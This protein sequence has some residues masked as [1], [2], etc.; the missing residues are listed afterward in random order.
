MRVLVVL[1]DPIIVDAVRER[2]GQAM[3]EGHSV[4]VC[5]V[6]TD[7]LGLQ[8]VLDA[9]RRVTQALRHALDKRAEGV[10]VFVASERDGDRIEDCARA[11]GATEVRP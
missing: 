8:A 1:R 6:P 10:P 9:Q 11:W 7:P 3:A 2:C 4:G 5:Y